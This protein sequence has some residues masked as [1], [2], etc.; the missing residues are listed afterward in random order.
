M[1]K[2]STFSGYERPCTTAVGF[3]FGLFRTS[4]GT[5]PLPR[6]TEVLASN[7][8]SMAGRTWFRQ[9]P[10]G[11]RPT[12]A[13]RAGSHGTHRVY[14]RTRGLW[15]RTLRAEPVLQHSAG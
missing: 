9:D 3:V 5:Y 4:A 11:S 13:P 10:P 2:G 12:R 7:P 6:L 15:S 1:I 14:A 8:F